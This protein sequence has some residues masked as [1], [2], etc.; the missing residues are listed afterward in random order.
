MSEYNA[1]GHSA[2]HQSL[3]V[4]LTSDEPPQMAATGLVCSL[5][6]GM[7]HS[8][9]THLERACRTWLCRYRFVF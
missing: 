7:L 5:F 8:Q 4:P 9:G 3:D 6:V 1:V 2:H